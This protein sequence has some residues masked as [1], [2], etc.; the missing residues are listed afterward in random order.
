MLDPHG[1]APAPVKVLA[2]LLLV[3]G[4]M[5]LVGS[6]FLWG[7]G[8]ILLAPAGVDL[9]YPVTDILVN[10]P[11]CLIAA[12]GLWTCRRYGYIA[13]QFTAG[14]FMYGSVEIFVQAAQGTLSSG[15][16]ILIP[17]SLA[18]IVALLL[19]FYLWRIQRIFS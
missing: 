14:V 6:L 18:V 2:A 4:L 19:V 10:A 17:Q 12:L 9:S 8:F 15:P 13:A 11:A 7:Q 5:A 1:K 3:F 16:E